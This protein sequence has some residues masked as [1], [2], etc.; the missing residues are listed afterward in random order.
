MT[1]NE[2]LAATIR[3]K[4]RATI[5]RDIDHWQLDAAARNSATCAGCGQ[6]WFTELIARPKPPLWM[7]DVQEWYH[8]ICYDRMLEYKARKR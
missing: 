1:K 5:D 6:R 3:S 7:K 8:R 4:E 2:E